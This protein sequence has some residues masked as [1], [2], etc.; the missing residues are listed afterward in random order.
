VISDIVTFLFN[1]ASY[2]KESVYWKLGRVV[3]IHGTLGYSL[4]SKGAEQTMVRSSR[5][6]SIVYS[7]REMS[8]N[9]Y[10]HFYECA[11]LSRTPS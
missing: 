1:F 9:T 8:S 6:I 2:T 4:K 7:I 10:D 3:G 11:R 5:D